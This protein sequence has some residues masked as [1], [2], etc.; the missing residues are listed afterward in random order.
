MVLKEAKKFQS[1]F[2]GRI[3]V[4]LAAA[5]AFVIAL[6]WNEVIK[7][8]IGAIVESLGLPKQMWIFQIVAAL[9]ITVIGVLGIMYFSKK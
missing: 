9:I 7:E 3:N 4:A 8:S 2:R 5:F 6:A 1:A